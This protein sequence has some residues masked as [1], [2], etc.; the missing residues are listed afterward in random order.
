MSAPDQLLVQGLFDGR[1]PMAA[2]YRGGTQGTGFHWEING[3]LGDILVTAPVG[4]PQMAPL[5]VSRSDPGGTFV[6]SDISNAL[7]DGFPDHPVPGNVARLYA[8]MA[9]DIRSGSRTAPRFEDGLALHQMIAG[10]QDV[11]VRRCG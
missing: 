6:P 8:R 7:H 1:I 5:L 4:H 9:S 10:I 2:H 3:S 11:A